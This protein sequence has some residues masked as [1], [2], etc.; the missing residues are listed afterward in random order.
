ME[1]IVAKNAES[2]VSRSSM[3]FIITVSAIRIILDK[4]NTV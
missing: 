2:I 3:L 4:H 1:S